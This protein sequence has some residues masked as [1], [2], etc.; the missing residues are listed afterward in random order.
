MV[1]RDRGP[2]GDVRQPA[3]D[4]VCGHER[5]TVVRHPVAD[6]LLATVRDNGSAPAAFGAAAE[7]LAT[8]LLWE[9]AR[10]FATTAAYVPG[11]SGE[12]IDVRR[13]ADPV[14]GIVILR[15]GEVFAGPFRGVFPDTP[16]FHL[17][18]RRDEATLD[19]YV[20]VDNVPNLTGQSDHLLILDPMLATGGSI[21]RKSVV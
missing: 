20:Y 12:P 16:L 7:R 17:G 21:D 11:F 2:M 3:R 14:A 6:E 4:D 1:D 5:L 10:D 19:H 18:V 8:F 9:A 13:L 15:A